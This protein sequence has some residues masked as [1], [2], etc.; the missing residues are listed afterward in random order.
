MS[1]LPIL[2]AGLLSLVALAASVELAARWWLRRE[3]AYYVFPPGQ[4]LRLH[5]DR[6]NFPE[7]EPLVR[8][9]VNGDGERGAEVPPA[10][11]GRSLYR[12]LVAGGSQPEGYLLDQDTSWPGA[13]HVLLNEPERLRALGASAAH[14]G[15]I[16]R[17]GVGSE[18][19]DLILAR[20]LPRYPRLSAIVILVG[21]SDVLRWLEEGAPNAPSS[22]PATA[23]L[24]RC[25][26]EG[27]FGWTPRKSAVV[28][29]LTRA[30]R[31]LLRPVQDHQ[32]AGRWI[33]KARA[34]RA[35]AKVVRPT[36]PEPAR[37]LD[38]FEAQFR[39]VVRRAMAHADRVVVVRQS[40]F[41]K[42]SPLT[43]EEAAHMWHGGAGQAWC[44]DVTTYYSIEVTSKLMALLDRRAERVADELGVEHIDL[45]AILEP[46]LATYYDYFHLTPSGA[47]A[48]ASAV[49]RVLLREHADQRIDSASPR[50]V[51]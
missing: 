9:D 25:H 37:M 30:R 38:H 27:P 49:A 34:M 16:A 48:V 42:P 19:L 10:A 46:S 50:C 17:S 6:E 24:F 2:G 44:E 20:V 47:H 13:L 7:L 1:A 32:R 33:A 28:E 43:P 35:N 21:A 8:F 15:S 18:A 45:R 4:R 39:K 51:A 29:L 5:V 14:A 22:V 3:G 26:P 31:R 23:D 11:R 12:V 36:M 40:W 41:D